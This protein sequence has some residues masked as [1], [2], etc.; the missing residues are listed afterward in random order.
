VGGVFKR[1][2]KASYR[3]KQLGVQDDDKLPI[4]SA[5]RDDLRVRVPL[6]N[7]AEFLEWYRTASGR[8]TTPDREFREELIETSILPEQKFKHIF[9]ERV[10][11][12]V[13]GIHWSPHFNCHE[14]LIAEIYELN[15][16]SEQKEILIELQTRAS[17]EYIW[18][19]ESVIRAKGYDANAKKDVARISETATWIL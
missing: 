4:D 7:L 2:T 3:L 14:V 15:P 16:T 19:D 10:R 1:L 8:E 18:C 13:D 11:T 12:H 17:E 6:K 5:S 9:H